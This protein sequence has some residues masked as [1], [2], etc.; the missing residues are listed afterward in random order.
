HESTLK[1]LCTEPYL[2]V[3]GKGQNIVLAKNMLHIMLASN[4]DWVVPATTD[5]RRFF[6]RDVSDAH[7]GDIP[8]FKAIA[9]QMNSGGLGA[10]LHDL[11]NRDIS[12]FEF[13]RAPETD[14]LRD[15]KT[16]SLPSI[17]RWWLAV[18]ERGF[19]YRSRHGAAYFREWHQFYTKTLLLR[20]YD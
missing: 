4:S 3:E 20:S 2:V 10:M 6:V 11:L 17:R 14:A 15:Q 9:N 8:Y 16:L 19:L 1:G 13:R 7:R 5:E 18:L 12:D